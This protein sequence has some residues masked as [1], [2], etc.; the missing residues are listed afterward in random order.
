MPSKIIKCRNLNKQML[1]LTK[2]IGYGLLALKYISE[3]P[4]EKIS[5]K[6]ISEN[7]KI[8][9]DFLSKTLQTL[10]KGGLIKSQKGINGGYTL[11]KIPEYISF[12]DVINALGID[13]NIVECTTKKNNNECERE[14]YCNLKP[15]MIKLQN[16]IDSLFK[17]LTIANIP[18]DK[19]N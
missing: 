5:A 12:L 6:E 2:K 11:A 3:F 1:K 15:N 19:L 13:M 18:S 4:G 17:K 16:E 8:S 9:F 7:L 14:N 10:A